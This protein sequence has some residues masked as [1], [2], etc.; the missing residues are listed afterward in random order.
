MNFIR[1]CYIGYSYQIRR[2]LI[3]NIP[4]YKENSRLREIWNNSRD[5]YVYMYESY[6]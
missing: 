1:C 3:K 2:D 4:Q 5:E 6:I